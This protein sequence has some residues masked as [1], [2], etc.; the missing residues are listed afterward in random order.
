MTQSFLHTSPFAHL[1]PPLSS[2]FIHPISFFRESW[3]VFRLHLDYTTEKTAHSRAQN[4]L[5]AQK[6]RIYRR[7]HGMEDLDAEEDQGVDVRGIVPW[8]DGL[9][10]PERARGGRRVNIIS[11]REWQEEGRPGETF[12]EFSIRKR[13]Q[14]KEMAARVAQA[15]ASRQQQEQMETEATPPQQPQRKRKVWLGIW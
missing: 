15:E 13:E 5:D 8:D 6:R 3:A 14:A 10:N 2:V 1:V 7:A 4:I 9:T 11:G 12:E